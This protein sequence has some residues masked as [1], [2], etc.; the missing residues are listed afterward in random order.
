MFYGLWAAFFGVLLVLALLPMLFDVSTGGDSSPVLLV[1][2]GILFAVFTAVTILLPRAPFAFVLLSAS[3][4]TVPVVLGLVTGDGVRV[5][6]PSLLWCVALWVCVV[7]VSRVRRLVREHPDL[8]AAREFGG[9]AGADRE[10]SA[11]RLKAETRRREEARRSRRKVLLI[12]GTVGG[13][14]LVA[15][16]GWALAHR[17]PALAP[18]L[19]AFQSAWAAGD[20]EAVGGFAGGGKPDRIRSMLQPDRATSF[21][22]LEEPSLRTYTPRRIAA[23]FPC[24]LDPAKERPWLEVET[25]WECI[26]AEWTLNNIVIR[27]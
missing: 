27:R 20:A 18:T 5:P 22:A 2:V 3:M 23:T 17:P 21:P 14:L 13:L 7:P 19:D 6:I 11:A 4:G 26:G 10:V 12:G 15:T 25:A 8:W 24:V 9:A 1:V 16:V